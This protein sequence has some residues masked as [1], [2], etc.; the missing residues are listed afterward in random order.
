[1]VSALGPPREQTRRL[2]A[3]RL[4]VVA[5]LVLAGLG[6]LL[7]ASGKPSARQH[8]H[9]RIVIPSVSSVPLQRYWF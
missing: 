8:A 3:Q 1:M 6:Q 2:I 9:L 4:G 7:S 5:Q